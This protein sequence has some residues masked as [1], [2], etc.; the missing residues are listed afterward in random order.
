MTLMVLVW[1][2][3]AQAQ[4]YY[5]PHNHDSNHDGQIGVADL[6][7][8][9]AEYGLTSG[10]MEG[11]EI[12]E[13]DFTDFESMVYDIWSGDIVID[14]IYVHWIFE[15]QHT[16][17]PIGS[18]ESQTDSIIYEREIMITVPSGY[19][20][21]GTE[22]FFTK[23]IP[24]EGKIRL[25]LVHN[26]VDSGSYN[27]HWVDETSTNSYLRSIGLFPFRYVTSS[28]PWHISDG[29]PDNF[30]TLDENGWHYLPM[31]YFNTSVPCTLFECIPYWHY[32]E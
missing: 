27:F 28:V 14:S 11:V 10:L 7:S 31:V 8:L 4:T 17:F 9:L 6:V 5:F 24:N 3:N 21:T 16:W 32:A 15:A 22:I 19:S 1:A 23:N 20:T 29:I 18:Q 30:W 25:R 26:G 2:W 12:P 13:Y